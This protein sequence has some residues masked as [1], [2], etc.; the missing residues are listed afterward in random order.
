MSVNGCPYE[1]DPAAS[2]QNLILQYI[3]GNFTTEAFTTACLL[4][5]YL[6]DVRQVLK[7]DYL[8]AVKVFSNYVKKDNLFIITVHFQYVLVEHENFP[9]H[10]WIRSVTENM[11]KVLQHYVNFTNISNIY[12]EQNEGYVGRM[13]NAAETK[14]KN[15]TEVRTSFINV[16]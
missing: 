10:I 5:Q 8:I 11:R 15:L 14:R 13:L 1:H 9:S 7:A 2:V 3:H 16:S 12:A 4:S 6:S